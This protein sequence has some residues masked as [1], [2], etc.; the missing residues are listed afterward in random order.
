MLVSPP[1]LYVKILISNVILLRSGAFERRSDDEARGPMNKI[2]EYIQFI[3]NKIISVTIN[4]VY[5]KEL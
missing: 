4:E 3:I 5:N 2:N 1:N